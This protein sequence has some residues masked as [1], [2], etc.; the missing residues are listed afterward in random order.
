MRSRNIRHIFLFFI[1]IFGWSCSILTEAFSMKCKIGFEFQE[2][3]KLCKDAPITLQKVPIF[4]ASFGGQK[5]W[6][7]EIDTNDLE[8]VTVPFAMDNKADLELLKM[9]ITSITTASKYLKELVNTIPDGKLTFETFCSGVQNQ[10]MQVA[11]FLK[12]VDTFCKVGGASFFQKI[13]LLLKER[14]PE[15]PGQDYGAAFLVGAIIVWCDNPILALKTINFLKTIPSEKQDFFSLWFNI[16]IK[17]SELMKRMR[18]IALEKTESEALQK[19]EEYFRKNI[20]VIGGML[21]IPQIKIDVN[22]EKFEQAKRI[23][24]SSKQEHSSIQT[25]IYFKP[26]MTVQHSLKDTIPLILALHG[27]G[28]YLDLTNKALPFKNTPEV[29]HGGDYLNEENGLLFLCALTLAGIPKYDEVKTSFD[30]IKDFFERYKQVDPKIGLYFLSRRPFSSMWQSIRDRK[31]LTKNFQEL[32]TERIVEGNSTFKAEVMPQI[33][34][35]NY[36]EE[37]Y[38][39]KDERI[40]LSSQAGFGIIPPD[41]KTDSLDFLLK[42]GIVSTAL[43][44]ILNKDVYNDYMK[45]LLNSIDFPQNVHFLKFNFQLGI[46]KEKTKSDALSPPWFLDP[47][48]SMGFYTDERLSEYKFDPA[49]GDA[50][51]EMRDI[52]Q[53]SVSFAGERSGTFLSGEKRPIMEDVNFLI[54]CFT[55]PFVLV[56]GTERLSQLK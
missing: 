52:D 42:R 51:V 43:I 3:H 18:Q 44:N 30:K 7:L 19:F 32:F 48:N 26:Q 6:H 49:Y 5:L 53:I 45:D 17:D 50:I 31:K 34:H 9:C 15:L 54:D 23:L 55:K 8:F 25:S 28:K 14:V 13:Q 46:I 16:L 20:T 33:E 39:E 11:D 36:A 35:M 22:F 40:D 10:Q 1:C 38:T 24:I 47:D 4:T 29:M 56:F 21:D 27:Y 12:I 41:L 37:F 2:V